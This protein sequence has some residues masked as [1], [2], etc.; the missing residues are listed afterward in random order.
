MSV[1]HTRNATI[2][3]QKRLVRCQT[4]EMYLDL[5]GH[6]ENNLNLTGHVDEVGVPNF[7]AGRDHIGLGV[8]QLDVPT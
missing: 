8:P 3:S 6:I 1:R 7:Y 2:Y 4:N 5:K